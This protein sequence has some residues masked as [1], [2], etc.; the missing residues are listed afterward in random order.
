MEARG[1]FAFKRIEYQL[2]IKS[3]NIKT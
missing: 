3:C 2:N 1:K